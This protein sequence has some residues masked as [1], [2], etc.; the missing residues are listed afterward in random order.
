ML[1]LVAAAGA[2]LTAASGLLALLTL[3]PALGLEPGPAG[4]GAPGRAAGVVLVAA[5]SCLTAL[6]LAS[7]LTGEA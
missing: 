7:V 1:L 6:V 2:A 3:G 5:A 4:V